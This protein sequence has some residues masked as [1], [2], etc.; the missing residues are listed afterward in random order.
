[1]NKISL[2]LFLFFFTTLFA[3][4]YGQAK[5]S[6]TCTALMTTL[7]GTRITEG[8]NDASVLWE[9]PMSSAVELLKSYG[10]DVTPSS[11]SLSGVDEILEIT[12]MSCV[13]PY[14]FTNEF[15]NRIDG[16]PQSVWLDIYDTTLQK[17]VARLDTF[18]LPTEGWI[19]GDTI[20]ANLYTYFMEP[21]SIIISLAT[22]SILSETTPSRYG[23]SK[24]LMVFGNHLLQEDT[25]HIGGPVKRYIQ[26]LRIIDNNLIMT[27]SCFVELPEA[28]SGPMAYSI[29]DAGL[30]VIPEYPE[31]STSP[32]LVEACHEVVKAFAD[33]QK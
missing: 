3:S 2:H 30:K 17:R 27:E 33:S 16:Q 22:K 23:S 29:D 32:Y 10:A 26:N 14:L 12:L 24:I 7:G 31:A 18:G 8:V 11:L 21:S 6:V 15:T 20:A 25:T 4:G 1:M 19:M 28:F 13:E 9:V 5:N